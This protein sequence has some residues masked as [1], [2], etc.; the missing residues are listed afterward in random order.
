MAQRSFASRRWSWPTV[1]SCSSTVVDSPNNFGRRD[2]SGPMPYTAVQS[3]F[4]PFFPKG[5]CYYWKSI[6]VHNLSDVCI[7]TLLAAAATRPSQ[8]SDIPIW[9]LG[10]AMSRVAP[11]A[12][13]YGRRDAPYL[14]TAE[15][16]WTDGSQNETN[17]RWA[18]DLVAA[19]RPFS[20]GGSYLNF[21]GLGE[22][23]EALLRDAWRQLRSTR[24]AQDSLRSRQPVPDES[25]YP[26]GPVC[27]EFLSLAA[28]LPREGHRSCT[29]CVADRK[30]RTIH[31]K[32]STGKT[33]DPPKRHFQRRHCR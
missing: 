24:G 16:T 31:V 4:D 29:G 10:G 11:A 12:T 5:H 20:Q 15:S 26:A 19:M 28:R 27:Q 17:I 3:A 25:Q 14:V 21:A 32:S 1:K 6:N 13:A 7:D 33:S 2:L 18:R 23:R 9:H 22:D 8:M 30:G